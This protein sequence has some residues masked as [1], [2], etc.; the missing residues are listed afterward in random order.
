M[1]ALAGQ[2]MLT[3]LS[4]EML[5]TGSVARRLGISPVWVSRLVAMGRLQAVS[6]PLGKLFSPA[7]VERLAAQRAAQSASGATKVAAQ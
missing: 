5:T 7:D 2:I 3:P 6:T 1:N 4:G